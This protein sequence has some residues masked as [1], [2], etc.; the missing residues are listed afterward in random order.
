M[1]A[2]VIE[3]ARRDGKD[4]GTV[5][6]Y[7]DKLGRSKAEREYEDRRW[8]YSKDPKERGGGISIF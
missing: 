7:D 6:Y 5:S 3:S 2:V 4:R 8:S 1:T